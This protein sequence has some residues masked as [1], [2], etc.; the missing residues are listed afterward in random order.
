MEIRKSQYEDIEN[1][2]KVINEAKQFFIDNQI[3][4][5]SPHYPNNDVIKNDIDKDT[6]FVVVDNDKIIGTFSLTIGEDNCYKNIYDGKWLSDDVYATI[7]RLAI[8]NAYKRQGIG[9]KIIQYSEKYCRENKIKSI[10]IDTKELNLPMRKFIDKN[11]FT[12]CGIIK[13]EDYSNRVAYEKML[14]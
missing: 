9:N 2:M 3:F 1:I 5:W 10:R 4:Q 13:T 12:Y 7:H 6:S 8:S 11:N 14:I